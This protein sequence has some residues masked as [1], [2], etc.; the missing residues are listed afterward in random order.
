MVAAASADGQTFAG[1][2]RG[3][4]PSGLRVMRI[5]GGNIVTR[6]QHDSA[7]SLLPSWD[8]SLLL[9]NNGVYSADLKALSPEQFRQK[10]CLPAYRP[11]YFVAV[12]WPD[13]GRQQ[14]N[15]GPRPGTV[16]SVY[17]TSDRSLLVKLPPMTEITSLREGYHGG[18][19]GTLEWHERVFLIPQFQRLVTL[20]DTRDQLVVRPF[21]MLETLD[22]AG[23]DYLFVDSLPIT[24]VD[25]GKAYKYPITVQS[26]KGGIKFSLDSGPQG[27]T[28]SKEG[29]L[30][31]QVPANFEPGPT[32]VIVTIEDSA[33]QSIFH[34][35]NIQV[36][37]NSTRPGGGAAKKIQLGPE[38]NHYNGAGR[39]APPVVR[40]VKKPTKGTSSAK[41][42]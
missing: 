40:A 3:V 31:W 30:S 34:T 14:P 32:G 18:S 7:G 42:E 15:G 20:A 10:T 4:S 6:Y 36:S 23:I 24:G 8:G 33:G 39:G 29:V 13:P 17:S 21:D 41:G 12:A 5:N 27:M 2:Q 28:L 38:S 11:G 22:K 35:F 16:L 19:P 37:E 26:K 1:F 9:T 25:P